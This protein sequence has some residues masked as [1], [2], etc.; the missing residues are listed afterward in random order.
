MKLSGNT[1]LITGGALG[2]GFALAE[3]F[4]SAGSEV[5]VCGRREDKLKEAQQ[6]LPSLNVRR[7]DVSSDTQRQSLF[8]SIRSEFPDLNVLVNNAGIQQRFNLVKTNADW[9]YY[10]KEIQVNLEA[11]IHLAML[12]VP[13]LTVKANAT[14]INISSG[15]A[16]IPGAFAPIYSATKAGLHSFS[17]SLRHQ[18]AKNN[19]KVIEVAPPAVNTD[20][21]G[22]D[23]HTFG[24]PLNEFADA[25]FQGFANGDPEI[26][27]GTSQKVIRMSRDEIDETFHLMN[28]RI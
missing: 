25:V 23:L 27:Y 20:L 18:V 11:P 4:I 2:I 1:V 15:L 5:I 16:F 28:S 6:K 21:G 12:F 26:G 14:I 3:R 10:H 19:I 24:V 13:H 8:E 17:M 22:A 7:C 9:S